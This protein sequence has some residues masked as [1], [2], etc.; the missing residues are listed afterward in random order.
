MVR[1]QKCGYEKTD[2]DSHLACPRCAVVYINTPISATPAERVICPKCG[3]ERTEADPRTACRTCGVVYIR[4]SNNAAP[5]EPG[6]ILQ[7]YYNAS[8]IH[9]PDAPPNINSLGQFVIKA[10]HEKRLASR[11]SAALA[12]AIIVVVLIV[13]FRH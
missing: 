9:K 13:I 5:A 11:R 7:Q 2:A 3:Y 6:K 10:P 12:M 8:D 4:L 1:C